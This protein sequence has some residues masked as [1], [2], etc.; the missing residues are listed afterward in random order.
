[1]YR[2]VG[3]LL[4]DKAGPVVPDQGGCWARCQ[5]VFE[6]YLAGVWRK[7]LSLLTDTQAFVDACEVLE[8]EGMTWRAAARLTAEKQLQAQKCADLSTS[9]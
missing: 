1:M 7:R 2:L 9:S 8:E 5:R 3:A 6:L 4:C